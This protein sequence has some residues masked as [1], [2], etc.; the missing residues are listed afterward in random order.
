MLLFPGKAII[1]F[2]SILSYLNQH[3]VNFESY[4][5][6]TAC[7]FCTKAVFGT[8]VHDFGTSVHDFAT[9]VRVFD[10]SVNVFDP[11]TTEAVVW[12]VLLLSLTLVG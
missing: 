7:D 11:F 1:L 3:N 6:Y 12:V 2:R 9:S 10:T 5:L 8:S 4:W